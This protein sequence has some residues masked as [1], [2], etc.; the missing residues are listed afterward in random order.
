MTDQLRKPLP[1]PVRLAGCLSA[2]LAL[3]ALT[4]VVAPVEA[5]GQRAK[6]SR[7]LEQRLASGSSERTRVILSGT[8]AEVDVI[9]SKHGVQIKKKLQR[10][11]VLEVTGEQLAALSADPAIGHL[12][13]DVPVRR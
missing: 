7:D 3:L 12:S 11:A 4:T 2:V 13:G 8:S 1:T 10:G 9:A 6:L 5:A